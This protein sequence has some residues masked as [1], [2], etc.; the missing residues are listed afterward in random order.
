MQGTRATG[1]EYLAQR[2]GARAI[3]QKRSHPLRRRVQHAADPDAV[4]HRSGGASEGDRHRAGRRSAGRQESAGPSRGA[5]H[6]R[7]TNAGP[8]RDAMRFDRMAVAMMQRAISSARARDGRA[9]RRCTPSSRRGPSLPCPTSSSCSA[10]RRTNAHLWFP[11][12]QGAPMTTPTASA[13]PCCIPKAAARCGLRSADPRAHP[14]IVFNLLS[15]PDDLPSCAKASSAR[16]RWRCRSRSIPIAAR[17]PSPG[18]KVKTDA[19]IDAWHQKT[20][21]T[22]HH[23]AGTCPMGTTR[24][25]CSIPRCGC[26]APSSL[27]VVDASAMPDLVSAHIN[28]TVLMMAEKAADMIRGRPALAA[29]S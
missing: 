14:R 2:T 21:I 22:A 8:F 19:E 26:W 9:R 23:P 11:L 28:A 24:I 20:V 17:K 6:V 15:A 27:R 13:R 5:D 16:A 3:A 12:I 1:V 4:G 10:A 25:A 18:A 29:A 7:R